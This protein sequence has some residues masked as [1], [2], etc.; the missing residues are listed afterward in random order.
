MGY[1][2]PI[3]TKKVNKKFQDVIN[4]IYDTLL[5]Q[6]LILEKYAHVDFQTLFQQIKRPSD[7]EIK[8]WI[9]AQKKNI[10]QKEAG[11]PPVLNKNGE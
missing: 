7:A 10:A 4:N 2:I 3:K 9:K 11:R 1:E 8:E 5:E 6:Y